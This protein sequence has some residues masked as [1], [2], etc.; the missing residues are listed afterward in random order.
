MQLIRGL[1]N[2]PHFAQGC[3][4][5]IGN[6]D[7]CHRGHQAILTQ[8]SECAKRLALPSVVLIFEP[9][10][11]E[12]FA[13]VE[14][15]PARLMRLRDKVRFMQ[16]TAVDYLLCLRFDRTFATLT[17]DAFIRTI[18]LQKLNVKHLIIGDDFRFGAQRAGDFSTLKQAGAQYGFAVQDNAS[19]MQGEQRISSTLIRH[20]L[21]QDNLPLAQS[22]LGRP[23]AVH[24]RVVHGKKLGRT[25]GFPTANVFLNRKVIPIQGVYAVEVATRQ[26]R[27]FG[28]ANMGNRPTVDGLSRP[29]L[30]VH[31]FDFSHSLYGQSI[32]VIFHHK[33][34]PEV[35]FA[36]LEQLKAQIWQ[37]AEKAK[38]FFHK[39]DTKVRSDV[40]ITPKKTL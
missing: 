37:D 28:V 23:Y 31:L 12:F 20:A 2:L 8:L 40:C 36:S 29:L 18:L 17:P 4:L 6:F 15:T 21:A 22:M 27:Y 24:G 30:E 25:I 32:E 38:Q 33:L 35:K 5:T 1:Y 16:T 10:P 14:H 7:G 39:K 9:Q 34:R 26:G 11:N 19:F 13:P 3:V